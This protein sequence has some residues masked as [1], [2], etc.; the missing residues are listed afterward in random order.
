MPD[1]PDLNPRRMK[2][3]SVWRITVALVDILYGGIFVLGGTANASYQQLLKPTWSMQ[4]WGALLV[5]AGAFFLSRYLEVGG[6]L[7]AVIWTTF[8][9]ASLVTEFQ[10]TAESA[11]GPVLLAAFAVFHLLI[12]YA[13]AAGLSAQRRG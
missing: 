6:V 5:L 7:G 12:T 3:A 8:A 11:S 2:Y 13:A 9:A 4:M 10:H 1:H